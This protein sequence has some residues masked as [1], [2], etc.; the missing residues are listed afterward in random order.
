MPRLS[1]R[2]LLQVAATGLSSTAVGEHRVAAEPGISP[3]PGTRIYQGANLDGWE[4]IVGDAVSPCQA[5]VLD[6][7]VE[8]I[9]FLDYSEV[10]ANVIPRRDTM[11]HNNTFKSISDPR[12]LDF[13]HTCTYSVRLPYVPMT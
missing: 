6:S 12:V 8:T 13:V 3:A 7:D 10:R 11:T 2:R 4:T 1:R 5:H 9:H